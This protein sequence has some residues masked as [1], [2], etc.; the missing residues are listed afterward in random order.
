PG[1]RAAVESAH[2]KRVAEMDLVNRS[3]L[4]RLHVGAE[5]A[6]GLIE[7]GMERNPQGLERG[8]HRR[9]ILLELKG[10][11][12]RFKVHIGTNLG[13][14][15]STWQLRQPVFENQGRRRIG[16]EVPIPPKQQ[17]HS[18]RFAAARF[19]RPFANYRLQTPGRKRYRV[20]LHALE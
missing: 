12:H 6:L 4:P 3:P 15:N 20:L 14:E 7:R 8:R 9:W 17:I 19:H 16:R 11:Q 5:L 2:A 10:L 1:Y 18:F 13:T